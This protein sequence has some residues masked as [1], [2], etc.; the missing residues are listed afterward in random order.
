VSLKRR[1]KQ[2]VQ[3]KLLDNEEANVYIGYRFSKGM[4][5]SL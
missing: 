2:H 1:N 5:F 3:E 4:E